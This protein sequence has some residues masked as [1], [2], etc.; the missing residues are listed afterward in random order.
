MSG[1]GGKMEESISGLLAAY[2]AGAVT[3]RQFIA[4]VAVF[5]AAS[6]ALPAAQLPAGALDHLSIQTSDLGRSTRFYCEGLGFTEA[7]GARPDGSVRLN[8]PKGG[9]ITLH[10]RSPAGQVDHF[11]IRL[12]GFSK[13]AVTTHLRARGITPIDE[14]DFTGTGAGFHVVDPDGLRV[15]FL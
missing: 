9:F 7:Q 3:R 15:Q 8:L 2:E 12:D 5:G 1:H 10:K 4:A 6:T 13:E 11:C 14:P